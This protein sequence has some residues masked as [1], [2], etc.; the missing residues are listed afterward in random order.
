M[1]LY[2]RSDLM[3][4]SI[5]REQG[6]CG[7]THARPVTRGVPA[8]KWELNCPACE[9]HL[10]GDGKPQILHTVPG[11]KDAGIPPSQ[12]RVPDGHP[13]WSSTWETV[14]QTP[15]ETRTERARVEQ[16][17]RQLRAIESLVNLK[18]AGIDL[19]G[20]TEIIH[21]LR[22]SGLPE[23]ALTSSGIV[24]CA[25][26]HDNI[27]GV[28][29]CGECGMSMNVRAQVEEE[30]TPEPVAVNYGVLHVASLKKICRERGVDD[31]GTKE[32]L[33]GRLT[34]AL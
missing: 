34:G 23:D 1:S 21:Y 18:S 6:G 29:F 26:G 32:Q 8:M 2:A 11:D 27:P 12:Q 31:K 3:A 28:K 20:R 9:S 17:E 4:V 16:G 25:A 15:D 14:P 19:T 7:A 13:H 33:I 5:P 30:K 24:L 22:R 10:R